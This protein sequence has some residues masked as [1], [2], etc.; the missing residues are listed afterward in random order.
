MS[1]LGSLDYSVLLSHLLSYNGTDNDDATNY[2]YLN[3]DNYSGRG[4]GFDRLNFLLGSIAMAAVFFLVLEFLIENWSIICGDPCIRS[5]ARECRLIWRRLVR[6][7]TVF[8]NSDDIDPDD[9]EEMIPITVRTGRRRGPEVAT[10]I[11][12]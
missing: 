6:Q 2:M 4:L 11:A 10:T 8:E 9:D 5:C 3:D 1:G 7:L 12:Q